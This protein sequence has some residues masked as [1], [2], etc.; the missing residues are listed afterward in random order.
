MRYPALEYQPGI[1]A[2]PLSPRAPPREPRHPKPTPNAHPGPRPP[3]PPLTTRPP[4]QP[5]RAPGRLAPATRA[6]VRALRREYAGRSLG[7]PAFAHL[8]NFRREWVL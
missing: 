7:T 5:R 1:A 6:A 2:E 4:Y 3:T 8:S